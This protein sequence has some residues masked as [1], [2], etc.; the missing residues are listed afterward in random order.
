MLGCRGFDGLFGSGWVTPKCADCA[1][2]RVEQLAQDFL[3][4]LCTEEDLAKRGS[5]AHL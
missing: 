4:L 1:R 2:C 5:S 3:V